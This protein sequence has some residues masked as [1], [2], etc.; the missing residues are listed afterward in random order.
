MRVTKDHFERLSKEVIEVCVR[1]QLP[2]EVIQTE[3]QRWSV[4]HTAKAYWMYDAGY[5]D[6]HI[7]TALKKLFPGR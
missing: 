2:I 4:F 6:A 7:N 3:S 1:Y 5:N